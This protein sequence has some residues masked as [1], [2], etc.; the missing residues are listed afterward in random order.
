MAASLSR[1]LPVA[2]G[3]TAGQKIIYFYAPW[4][5]QMEAITY[6]DG[7]AYESDADTVLWSPKA[8]AE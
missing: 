5:L 8:P 1:P 2:D 7:M 4:G 6:P 3:P